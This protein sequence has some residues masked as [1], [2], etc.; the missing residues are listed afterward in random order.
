MGGGEPLT[1]EVV[2]L[3][4]GG[5]VLP[6]DQAA[7]AV[8]QDREQPGLQVR[9]RGELALGLGRVADRVVAGVGRGGGGRSRRGVRRRACGLVP[10][11]NWRWAWSAL[12]IVSWTRSSA[13]WT[14]PPVR[15]R[16]KARRCGTMAATSSR[17]MP[18]SSLFF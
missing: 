1:L 12:R 17:K 11:V 2:V 8:A 15:L 4:L 7:E 5:D 3:D 10:G 13:R 6:G 9:A 18:M 14:S 16:A